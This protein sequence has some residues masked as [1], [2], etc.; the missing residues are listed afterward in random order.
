VTH[1]AYEFTT[2][3]ARVAR[4]AFHIEGLMSIACSAGRPLDLIVRGGIEGLP[5]LTAVF[6]RVSVLE[7]WSFMK[8]MK[9]RRAVPQE[10]GKLRWQSSPTALGAPLDGLFAANRTEVRRWIEGRMAA[11][12]ALPSAGTVAR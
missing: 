12:P 7:T 10:D 4:R 6:N 1:I 11:P 3:T 2:G 5:Q 8:T 9:R